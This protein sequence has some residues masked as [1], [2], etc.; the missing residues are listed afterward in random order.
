MRNIILFALCMTFISTSCKDKS[1]QPNQSP[2]N[3][4]QMLFDREG[5]S[6]IVFSAFATSSSDTFRI[7]VT[8][9]SYRDTSI[10]RVISR[11]SSNAGMLDTLTQALN[12]QIQL[13]GSFKQDTSMFVGTWASMY[14][15]NTSIR[16]EVTNVTLRSS[17]LQLESIVRTKL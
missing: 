17:L 11:N 10:Q 8:K 16:T 4:S 15:L 13:S 2:S 6:N 3:Y 1:T 14:M 12:G 7:N 9:Y 5:G